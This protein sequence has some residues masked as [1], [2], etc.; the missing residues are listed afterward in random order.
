M[1]IETGKVV[2]HAEMLNDEQLL[3]LSDTG[4]AEE[5]LV[6]RYSGLVRACARPR[7]MRIPKLYFPFFFFRV[8]LKGD[9]FLAFFDLLI[10]SPWGLLITFPEAVR[11]VPTGDPPAFSISR[12]SFFIFASPT[13]LPEWLRRGEDPVSRRR[14]E[15]RSSA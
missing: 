10:T 11:G 13:P 7:L 4:V 2:I 9:F 1:S 3:S 6:R 5:E 8:F 12:F 15:S 14:G